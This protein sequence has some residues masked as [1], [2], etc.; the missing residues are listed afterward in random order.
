[1]SKA[2]SVDL[3]V[4]VVAAAEAGTPHREVADRFGVSAASLS[5]WRALLCSRAD[6]RL[7]PLG[8]DHRSGRSKVGDQNNQEQA[9]VTSGRFE[10]RRIGRSA[11][12]SFGPL[13][14]SQHA[15]GHIGVFQCL[16]ILRR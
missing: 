5:L 2:L 11:D 1:M 16:N 8:G 7:G 15:V 10:F 4:R 6:V 12:Y 14:M 3:R 9:Q 13:A